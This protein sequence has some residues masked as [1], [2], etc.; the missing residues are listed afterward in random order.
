MGR[1]I[2]S[3]QMINIQFIQVIRIGMM[4]EEDDDDDL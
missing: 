3:F 1:D 4:E 2:G